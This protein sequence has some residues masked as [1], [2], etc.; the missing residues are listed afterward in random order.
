[1]D[2]IRPIPDLLPGLREAALS[3][4]LIPFVGA[5]ASRI[6][7]CP[8]WSEF[9]D[10][11]LRHF[12]DLGKF[13]HGQLAQLSQQPPR[14]KL[15]IALGLQR[16]HQVKIDFAKILYPKAD[17]QNPKGR[18]LYEALSKL[19]KTFVTTNYD[20]WLDTAISAPTLSVAADSTPATT[21]IADPRIPIYNVND[22]TIDKLNLA[23]TVFHLHGSMHDPDSMILTTQHYVRHYAND[24][25]VNGAGKENIILTFL[26]Y[27]F[28]EK[29]VLFV[30]YGLEELEIL[31]YVIGKARLEDTGQKEMRHFLLQ[32]FFSHEQ[33]LARSLTSYYRDCGI[34]LIPFLRD[35]KDWDQLIDVLE[36]FARLAPAS[37]LLTVQKLK[38]MEALL[39]E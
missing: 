6:A 13:T 36:D 30:G 32:G 39:D 10:A 14:V 24:R 9:A 18:R 35:Q 1:M 29:N 5:G 17:D 3:G 31:E 20:K 19:G 11:A 28:S 21:P 2:E 23:N 34:E 25:L 7:G 12:V 16:Q 33:E 22:F 37:P 27:L 38:E 4:T 26:T 8:N 15:S